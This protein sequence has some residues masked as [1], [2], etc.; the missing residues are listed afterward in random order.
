MITDEHVRSRTESPAARI[1]EPIRKINSANTIAISTNQSNPQTPPTNPPNTP[2]L[3][4]RRSPLKLLVH[5][6]P[7]QSIQTSYALQTPSL[8]SDNYQDVPFTPMHKSGK[9]EQAMLSSSPKKSKDSS[10]NV[11]GMM[12]NGPQHPLNDEFGTLGSLTKEYSKE[13]ER[14]PESLRRKERSAGWIICGSILMIALGASIGV[15]IWLALS[16]SK[17]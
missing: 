3:P 11:Q 4:L 6:Q 9:F 17:K 13:F 7:P 5:G 16:L 14:D 15:C 12:F 10:S 8:I 2:N 1:V